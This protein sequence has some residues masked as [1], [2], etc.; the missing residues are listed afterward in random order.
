MA[1]VRRKG[2]VVVVQ[3]AAGEPRDAPGAHVLSG[4]APSGSH[5]FFFEAGDSKVFE[6]SVESEIERDR[7]LEA[8]PPPPAGLVRGYLTKHKS[9]TPLRSA[10]RL[11]AVLDPQT[12]TLRFYGS[13][14]DG[15]VGRELRE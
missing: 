12:V 10:E 6:C 11:Y 13:M 15:H 7:W 1:D 8:M 14:I 2:H 9:G 5:D 4:H 3:A